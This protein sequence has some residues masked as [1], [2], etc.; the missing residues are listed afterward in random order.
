LELWRTPALAYSAEADAS[1]AKAGRS[2]GE[3][4][5]RRARTLLAA[6]CLAAA[7][8]SAG[9][10]PR[11]TEVSVEGYNPY[12]D[13]ENF[14]NMV[15]FRLMQEDS[16][17]GLKPFTMIRLQGGVSGRLLSFAGGTA[18]DVLTWVEF[19]QLREFVK[20]GFLC[21]LNEFIGEDRDG[22]GLIGDD[23]A[24]WSGWKYVPRLYRRIATVDGKVYGLPN[25]M[26][27]MGAILYR[28][29]MFRRAG[30]DP[31]ELPRDWDELFRVAQKL[32]DPDAEVPGARSRMGQRGLLIEPRGWRFLPFIWAA[33]GEIVMQGKTNPATGKT[34]WFPHDADDF[35]DPETGE[36]LSG[37]PSYWRPTFADEGGRRA[38]RFYQ[39]LRFQ[40]WI[41]DPQSGEPVD[42][43]LDEAEAGR[44]RRE[45]GS[46]LTF[47]PDEVITGVIR[48]NWGESKE[49]TLELLRRGEV[50]MAFHVCEPKSLKRLGLPPDSLGLFAVPPHRG[51]GRPAMLGHYHWRALNAKLAGRENSERR[52]KAWR[53]LSTMNGPRGAKWH[54]EHM[55]NN[56]QAAFL[57]PDMLVRFGYEEY[58]SWVPKAWQENYRSA[59]RH[60]RPEP[61]VGFWKPI[62]RNALG[63]NVIQLAV[64]DEDFDAVAGLRRAEEQALLDMQSEQRKETR[65]KRLRPLRSLA[66]VIAAFWVAGVAFFF[67]LMIRS[68]RAKARESA[69][70][71]RPRRT[72]AGWMRLGVPFLIMAPA[73]LLMLV[74]KY[75]PL[76]DGTAISFE[77][78]R[79]FGESSWVGLDNYI[80]CFMDPDFTTYLLVTFKFVFA[81]ILLGF[82]TPI[83]LALLL[84]E[85]PR[86]KT[87]WRTIFF[88]PQ[89]S[90][91][92]V[93]L[94]LWK[95]L[96]NP[97]GHG[98]L[99]RCLGALGFGP[100]DWL[101]QW[102]MLA[103]I[104]P[105]V[106]AGAGIGSLIYLAALK[107]VPEELY[108]AADVDGA[109]VWMKI[110]HVTIPSILPLVIINFI[111]VFIGTF[112]TM[113]NIFALTGGGPGNRTRVMSIHIWYRAFAD[114]QFGSATAYAWILGSMLLGLTV[115]QLRILNRVDFRRAEAG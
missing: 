23:E 27:G 89:V 88:L 101:A 108:E 7:S 34:H 76:A 79:I 16:E 21:P 56:G 55:V 1:A 37:E 42:L 3:G 82:F 111:G 113:G 43:S 105:G 29:D 8:A 85:I 80:R 36:D 10:P 58:L 109:S 38:I 39:K 75:Y 72:L 4:G 67:V 32:T 5:R 68:L 103:V 63:A 59:K 95:Q 54:V 64:M 96:Y 90:S 49:D 112:H 22:D 52:S 69:G 106:W 31:D 45:D 83:F 48:V 110:R 115:I 57:E 104:L 26:E 18:P 51:G 62:A 19:H 15:C 24:R 35:V 28:K 93:V 44:A 40:K 94:F 13:A 47:D 9:G 74:W 73:L 53:V 33:G 107:C 61:Y 71:S 98:F 60:M 87:I 84:N 11:R 14:I 2:L 66:Y 91:G 92:L 20:Q 97:T 77:E 65:E 46:V 100:V 86:G 78:Y 50:A 17:L 12:G 81:T 30:H 114:L 25:L 70:A 41:R 6:A 99:N 102:P